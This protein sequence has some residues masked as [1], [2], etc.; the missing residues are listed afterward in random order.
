MERQLAGM[1]NLAQTPTD[2]GIPATRSM[3]K[4]KA[5]DRQDAISRC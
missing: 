4:K 3:Q 1:L 5:D 2:K